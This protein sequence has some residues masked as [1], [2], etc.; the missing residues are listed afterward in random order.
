[1]LLRAKALGATGKFWEAADDLTRVLYGD[2]ENVDALILRGSAYRHM[3]ANDLALKDISQALGSDPYNPDGLL[4]HGLI[5][6]KLGDNEAAKAV[7]QSLIKAHPG[8]EA[9]ARAQTYLGKLD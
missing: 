2:G 6:Q 4:E 7:W 3:G 9:S 5:L 1:L 8:D